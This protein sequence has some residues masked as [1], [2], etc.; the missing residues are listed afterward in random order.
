MHVAQEEE[1]AYAHIYAIKS[2]KLGHKVENSS[3]ISI[4]MT[5]FF[6]ATYSYTDRV[7]VNQSV[8]IKI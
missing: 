1:Y 7:N 4:L 2:A 3:I 8:N 5:S 6:F